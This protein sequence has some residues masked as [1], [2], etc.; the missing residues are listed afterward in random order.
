MKLLETN[1]NK[2]PIWFMRQ[3][4]RY[5]PEYR[6]IR[7]SYKEF[8]EMCYNPKAV[9]EITLQPIKRFDLDFAIIFSDILVLPHSLG[10]KVEFL[11]KTGPL[12]EPFESGKDIEKMNRDFSGCAPIYDSISEVRAK[13]PQNKLLIGFAGSPWTV[14]SYLLESRSKTNFI[15]SK[16]F[17]YDNPEVTQNLIDF[18]TKKTI[19]HLQNQIE[20]GCD[21]IQLFDSWSGNISGEEYQKFVIEPTGIIVEALKASS[22]KIPIIGFPRGSGASYDAY[23]EKTGI[24]IISVDQ[25]TPLESMQIFQKKVV[26]QGNLDPVVL[27][28]NKDSIR[29]KTDLIID[30]LDKTNLIFNLGHGILPETPI[31]NVHFLVDYVRKKL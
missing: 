11:E 19:T 2:I 12:L 17:I 23:I 3:A 21:L 28:S 6:N 31:E 4:G 30:H 13:L 15:N 20:A 1:K 7:S 18:I 29:H 14:A 5:L 25:F 27:L 26:V 9:V 10:W 22:P 24:D 8:L 16:K